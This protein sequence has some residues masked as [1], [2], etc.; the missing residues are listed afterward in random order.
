M[1]A[2]AQHDKEPGEHGEE[3]HEE[4]VSKPSSK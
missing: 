3:D 1:L 4:P 2:E